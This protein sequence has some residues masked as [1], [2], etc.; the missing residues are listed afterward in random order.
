MNE[1]ALVSSTK[2]KRGRGE[3]ERH[4]YWVKG[5]CNRHAIHFAVISLRTQQYGGK[6]QLKIPHYFEK[7]VWK[8]KSRAQAERE[9]IRQLA[10][11]S[12]LGY[13]TPEED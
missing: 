5:H 12:V 4:N 10:Q 7:R 1:T 11:C 2:G 8:C 6:W 13:D 3:L 9:L